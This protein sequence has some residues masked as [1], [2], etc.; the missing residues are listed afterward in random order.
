MTMKRKTKIVM[1]STLLILLLLLIGI[2]GILE[3]GPIIIPVFIGAHPANNGPL[4]LSNLYEMLRYN[5]TVI[6]VT[7]WSKIIDSLEECSNILIIIV[8]PEA[9]YKREEVESIL[10]ITRKCR[11]TSII[12]GDETGNTNMILEAMRS[13]TRIPGY[14]PEGQYPIV[15]FNT[16]WGWSGILVLDRPSVLTLL[17][18]TPNL[19]PIGVLATTTSRAISES[20]VYSIVENLGNITVLVVGDGSIFLNQ[21]IRSNTTMDYRG[22]IESMIKFMCKHNCTILLESS[23]SQAVHPRDAFRMLSDPSKALLVDPISLIISFLVQVIHPSTWLPPLL[24]YLNRLIFN[25]LNIDYVRG[26]LLLISILVIT[27]TIIS[28]ERSVPDEPLQ[29]TIEVTWY[30][31]AS[32]RSKLLEGGAKLDKTDFLSLYSIVDSLLKSTTGVSLQSPDIV[33]VLVSRGINQRKAL[34]YYEFMNKYYGRASSKSRWPLIVFWGSIV[35]KAITLSEDILRSIGYSLM[36]YR[37]V[38]ERLV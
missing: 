38:E 29:D 3:K 30:G 4:G 21:V 33:K 27:L 1:V 19:T 25:L 32:F 6:L 34:D 31:H 11:S 28:R 10:D 22:F 12:I 8:S 13:N 36:E 15:Y 26:M 5:Y 16:P 35:R 7:N 9:P 23:K 14:S 2:I 18:L 24:D 20:T 37:G 17:S